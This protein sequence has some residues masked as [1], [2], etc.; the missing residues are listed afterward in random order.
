MVNHNFSELRCETTKFVRYCLAAVNVLTI[1]RC[2]NRAQIQWGSSRRSWRGPG[3]RW[4]WRGSPVTR[5]TLLA[6]R[7]WCKCTQAADINIDGHGRCGRGT[8]TAPHLSKFHL[9][10]ARFPDRDLPCGGGAGGQQGG[11]QAV[12][13]P[14]LPGASLLCWTYLHTGQVLL[15][16]KS[17]FSLRPRGVFYRRRCGGV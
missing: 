7:V 13:L 17:Q 1:V 6:S 9:C 14:A 11:G 8:G 15:D 16:F 5:T 12:H 4:R 2:L 3:W 10:S